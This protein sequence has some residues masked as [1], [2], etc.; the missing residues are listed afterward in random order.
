VT[1][2]TLPPK[3]AKLKG[4]IKINYTSQYI[5]YQAVKKKI[6]KTYLRIQRG[7][8]LE[9]SNIL[10]KRGELNKENFKNL[11]IILLE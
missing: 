6:A 5:T 8:L 2:L 1:V 4:K 11:R 10:P 7:P 9:S 3:I